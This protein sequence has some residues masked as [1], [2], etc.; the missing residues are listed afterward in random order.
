[1]KHVWTS[2]AIAAGA[3]SYSTFA[4]APVAEPLT[5]PA[6]AGEG[7][8]EDFDEAVAMARKEGKNLL[9]DFTG[10]DWCGWCI[11]LHKEVFDHE[12]WSQAAKEE[13]VLVAL[14]FPRGEE[15]KAKVP[16]PKR[17][18][19][20]SEMYG[21]KGF[22]TIL[23]MTPDGDVFG[24]TG[25]EAGG[26]ESYLAHMA[27]LKAKGMPGLESAMKLVSAFE[28][29]E[30]DARKAA[31]GVLAS[32]LETGGPGVAGERMLKRAVR[33]GMDSDPDG[34]LGMRKPAI[35]ALLATG[36]SD[37]ALLTAA[38]GVDAANEEGLYERAVLVQLQNID[39]ESLAA[40]MATLVKFD[41]L[42]VHQDDAVGF[43]IYLAGAYFASK[44]LDQPELSKTY[45]KKAKAIGYTAN[46]QWTQLIEELAGE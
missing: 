41:A 40:A 39:E 21:V 1:M 24:R 37:A 18:Q 46:A 15:V 20:L 28:A 33:A 4:A 26:P 12:S 45:A 17:N 7:W 6:V 11:R 27:D 19:E 13:Y 36:E 32:K 14:D 2:L 35:R 3:L 31:F 22:P 23:L 34:S 9:V 5:S 42:G 30:G 16:N 10:S 25:Y 29:A 38:M 44:H 8:I 43:E